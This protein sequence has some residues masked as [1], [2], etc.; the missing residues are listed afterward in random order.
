[1]VRDGESSHGSTQAY[2]M[3]NIANYLNYNSKLHPHWSTKGRITGQFSEDIMCR[4]QD[5][6]LEVDEI[7][8]VETVKDQIQETM[9][10]ND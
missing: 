5:L 1:M 2:F 10:W 3:K 6:E 9:E 8:V 4:V 7:E